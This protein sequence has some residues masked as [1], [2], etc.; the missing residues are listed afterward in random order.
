MTSRPEPGRG[1]R[2]PK[3]LLPK[4]A[5]YNG[6]GGW[7]KLDQA[8][9]MRGTRQDNHDTKA[10]VTCCRRGIDVA[11]PRGAGHVADEP[12]TMLHYQY[13][14]SIHEWRCHMC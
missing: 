4:D 13:S 12:R 2:Q 7:V 14:N 5:A 3:L 10:M 8:L 9:V 6:A 11:P 1:Q